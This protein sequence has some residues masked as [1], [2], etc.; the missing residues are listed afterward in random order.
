MLTVATKKLNDVNVDEDIKRMQAYAAATR[1]SFAE[2]L[3]VKAPKSA[4]G[5]LAGPAK[6]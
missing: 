1:S 4:Y 6:A 5:R 2:A 3:K